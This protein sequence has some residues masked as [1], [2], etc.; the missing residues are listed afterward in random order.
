MWASPLVIAATFVSLNLY[1]YWASCWS[2]D[3]L[4]LL[5]YF[6][7]C[8]FHFRHKVAAANH[9]LGYAE[10]LHSWVSLV[11]QRDRCTLCLGPGCKT[12][13]RQDVRDIILTFNGSLDHLVA[14]D[15]VLS[16]HY[17]ISLFSIISASLIFH[18][19]VQR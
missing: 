10:G 15:F 17:S 12:F 18:L 3:L 11:L 4:Y 13:P 5:K 1:L 6:E 19:C 16:T 9:S 14:F 7:S 8:N 2:R